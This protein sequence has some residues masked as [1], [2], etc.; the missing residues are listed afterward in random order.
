MRLPLDSSTGYCSL[1][2]SMP[3]GEDRQIVGPVEEIGDAAK[4]FRLAL[5]AEHA[6]G[7]EQ[8]FQRGVGGGID[9]AVDFQREAGPARRAMVRLL[10]SSR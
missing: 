8:A 5:G 9:L 4:A 10:S 7:Q 1:S 6:A 3:H 2:A